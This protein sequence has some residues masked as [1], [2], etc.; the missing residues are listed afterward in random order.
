MYSIWTEKYRPQTFRDFKGQEKI[1]ERVKAMVDQKNIGNFLFAGPA[2]VGKSS[3]ALIIAK[4]LFGEY[5]KQNFLE[6]NASDDRGIDIVRNEI[7]N[8]ARLK[9]IGHVPFKIIFLDECDSL[10]KEAQQALRRTMENF[11]NTT[12]FILSC[13]YS[14]KLIDPIQSRCTIFR[15]K[16]LEK[17]DF[18]EI[19]S[20]I[21]KGESLKVD[22]KSLDAMYEVCDGDARRMKNIL[23]SCAA[24]NKNITENLIYDLV[25]AAR[26]KEVKEVLETAIQGDFIQA[27]NKLLDVMLQHGLS[28]LDIIKQI[29]KEIWNL[30]ISDEKK[31][32]LIDKCGDIEFRMVEGSDEFVQ[33]ESLL[34][35][36]ILQ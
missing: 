24:I 3:M 25:S 29:Q 7:K 21:A 6:L 17:K 34:A 16:P 31:V 19:I 14:S 35:N 33:L 4:T 27:R 20:L 30:K 2:G 26:P 36:F 32:Q 15:F 5:W 22:K 9:S 8:F 13:N 11:T 10:T 28:G 23:Q 18:E 12:R 1:V